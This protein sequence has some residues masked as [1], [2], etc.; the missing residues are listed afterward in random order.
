MPLLHTWLIQ[1]IELF[2]RIPNLVLTQNHENHPDNFNPG[3]CRLC[4]MGIVDILFRAM[5]RISLECNVSKILPA[6]PGQSLPWLPRPLVSRL[7]IL[8]RFWSLVIC[9]H[10]HT[11]AWLENK[12][13]RWKYTKT[14]FKS[15]KTY[16]PK[17]EHSDPRDC[18]S[19][20]KD[21]PHWNVRDN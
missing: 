8:C 13:K 11:Q 20:D 17:H 21:N 18:S 14:I 19:L 15:F 3:H 6:V 9:R 10:L 12:Q 2:T 1:I 7:R 4:F 16:Q 5:L